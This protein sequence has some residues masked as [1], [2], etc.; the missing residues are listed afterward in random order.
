MFGSRKD[1]QMLDQ[2]FNLK[3]LGKQM[4]RQ[5][6]KCEKDMEAARMKIK[7]AIEKGNLE[8][9][10]IYGQECIQKKQEQLNYMRL[11]SQIDAVAGM[12]ERQAKMNIVN[13]N[14]MQVVGTLSKALAA[15][16]LERVQM[17]MEQFEKIF[18]SLDVQT[19]AVTGAMQSQINLSTPQDQVDEI[20]QQVATAHNLEV[21]LNMPNAKAVPAVKQAEKPQD[22]LQARLGALR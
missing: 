2:I 13:K 21:D 15:T 12:M 14:M 11:G 22:D 20:I 1:D 5:A 8:G 18:E 3:F 17:N 4:A 10:R 6:T 16:P 9:A 19:N 7:K